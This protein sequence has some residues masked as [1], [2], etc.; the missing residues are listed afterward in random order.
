LYQLLDPIAKKFYGFN[1]YQIIVGSFNL[2]YV[3]PLSVTLYI[4][5]IIYWK[6]HKIDSILYFG[7][8]SYILFT[9]Y[10]AMTLIWHSDKLWELLSITRFD[11]TSYEKRHDYPMIIYQKR[12]IIYTYTLTITTI[13]TSTCFIISSL[14][15]SDVL[16]S[17]TNFK[18]STNSYRLNI[19]NI[20]IFM[21]AETYKNFFG[22]L[23]TLESIY[24]VIILLMINMFDLFII[25]IC[26]ALSGQLRTISIAAAS[27]GHDE[28]KDVCAP[29]SVSK[30]DYTSCCVIN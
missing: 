20:Y 24:V 28:L 29:H 11:L 1:L 3:C 22:V 26:V 23:V 19:L 16:I 25:T 15:V 8:A 6:H 2:L 14:A 5:G 7:I 4:N 21:P 12:S 10:K 13:L 18:G 9:V 27:V 30:Y 17:M